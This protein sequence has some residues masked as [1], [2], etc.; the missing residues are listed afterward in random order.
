MLS[1]T[2]KY[3][4]NATDA[5]N[6]QTIQKALALIPAD[7]RAL[8]QGQKATHQ[9]IYDRVT[10]DL[11]ADPIE[12]AK[13]NEELL[14]MQKNSETPVK[15]LWERVFAAGRYYYLSS[16]W[17][18]SS[19]DLLGMWCGDCG[20]GWGGFYH[21][22]ANANLQV[23]QGNIGDMPEAMEGYF[24]LNERWRHDQEINAQKLLAAAAWWRAGNTPGMPPGAALMAGINDYYPYQF[25]TGE[26]PW[27][28]YPFWE[29][30]LITGDTNFLRNRLYPIAEGHGR[31]L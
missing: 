15:A 8:I 22:D 4:T 3:Y 13:S 25:A 19:P 14:A 16:S 17:E 31:I 5:W 12:R 6:Q 30:Y 23:A 1:R 20:A 7:Y 29:H 27:L 10:I 28:L 21:L 2:E 24:S 9:A 11:H 26:E 18:Q